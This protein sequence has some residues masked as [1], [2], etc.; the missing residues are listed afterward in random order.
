MSAERMFP[1]MHGKT[2]RWIP[3][4]LITPHEPQAL[5]NH[6]QTLEKLADRHGLSPCEAMAVLEDRNWRD[7]PDAEA[8]LLKL[9][10]DTR[11]RLPGG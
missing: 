1:I 3:W 11:A 10:A 7:D 9:I 5:K 6:G 2:A 4:R 8:K